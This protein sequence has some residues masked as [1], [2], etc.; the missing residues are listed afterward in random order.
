VEELNH[1]VAARGMTDQELV[2]KLRTFKIGQPDY[3]VWPY[4]VEALAR[5]LD[6][7]RRH[8]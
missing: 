1:D 6:L 8:L 7:P 2:L 3:Q 4:V 5:L